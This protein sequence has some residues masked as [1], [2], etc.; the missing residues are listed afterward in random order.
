MSGHSKW[1]TIKR[2]KGKADAARGKLFNRLIR[3]ITIAARSGGGDINANPRLRTAVTSARAAN[4]PNKNVESAI[5]KG[6]G[7]LEGVSFEEVTFEGYGPGG[8]AVMIEC[9]TD[10]RNRTVAEVRHVLGKHGGNL[11]QSNSVAWMFKSKGI[12]RMPKESMAEDTLLEVVLEAGAEDMHLY[13]EEY[14]IITGPEN[15]EQVR[16]ALEKVAVQPL[17]AELTKVADNPVKVEGENVAKVM[18]LLEALDDLDDT[19]HVY[20]NYDIADEDME[21]FAE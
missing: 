7:Q 21:K 13:G 12:I 11:G 19:Q 17:S 5:L 8:I 9:M 3:E 10:N 15:F 20:A 18:R 14:E 1:A 4:M 6:T 2:S 16:S